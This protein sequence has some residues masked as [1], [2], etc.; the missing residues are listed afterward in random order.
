[1]N[2]KPR[3]L[4]ARW[5]VT[6]LVVAFAMAMLAVWVRREGHRKYSVPDL[7]LQSIHRLSIP[8]REGRVV[9]LQQP[10]GFI[11]DEHPHESELKALLGVNNNGI[12]SP[13]MKR[14]R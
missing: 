7:L 12:P 10:P 5:L 3:K 1:M 11:H 4:P 14:I 6:I 13:A 8:R 9:L 2:P